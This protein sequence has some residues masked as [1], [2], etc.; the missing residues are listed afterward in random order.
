MKSTDGAYYVGLNHVRA[1][2]AFVVFTWH[3]NHVNGGQY[4]GPGFFVA[5]LLTEGHTG[6]A[7]FMT[8]SGYLFA[9]LL[10][11]K[12]V[13]YKSFIWNR[14]IRLLPL[15]CLVIA[16]AGIVKY[17]NGGDMA[18]FFP[19][20][21][22]RRCRAV[23]AKWWMV[24]HCRV[25]FL[26]DSSSFTTG[27]ATLAVRFAVRCRRRHIRAMHNIFRTRAGPIIGILDDRWAGRSI[28]IRYSGFSISSVVYQPSMVS[29]LDCVWV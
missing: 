13:D 21:F 18:D 3:F 7:I 25:S 24:Y 22:K 26:R 16:I 9:K 8:L 27:I 29:R 11:G 28:H 2:A 15:L 20:C 23:I 17:A 12:R 1:L 14:L 10:D 5:S 6:V 19:L 4:A